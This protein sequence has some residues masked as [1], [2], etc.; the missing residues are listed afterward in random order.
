MSRDEFPSG[1]DGGGASPD[2]A[3]QECKAMKIVLAAI[4]L[5]AALVATD[6]SA[7][8][9]NLTGQNRCIEGCYAARPGHLAYVT[10]NGWELNMVHDAR[11]HLGFPG[12]HGRDLF[13]RRHDHSIR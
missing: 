12:E 3:S 1:F 2:P 4:A 5:S 8:G 9:V 10:Q 7:Q 11:P 6:A 13:S